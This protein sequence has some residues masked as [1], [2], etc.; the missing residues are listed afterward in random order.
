MAQQSHIIDGIGAGNHPGDQG[1]D[2]Q[3]RVGTE[4]VRQFQML[5]DQFPEPGFP[6][7]THDRDQPRGRHEIRIIKSAGNSRLGMEKLHLR[8]APLQGE[9]GTLDKSYFP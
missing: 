2:L 1:R 9:N 3:P 4:I 5:I 7:Q 8:N 6:G